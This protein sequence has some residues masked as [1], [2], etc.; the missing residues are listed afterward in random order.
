MQA[1]VPKVLVVSH[2]YGAHGG[3]IERVVDRLLQEMSAWG[4]CK[5]I[6]AASDVDPRPE[7][8]S[9]EP[10]PMK[11]LNLLEKVIGIPWPVWGPASLKRLKEQ[12]K[13]ADI[14]WLHDTLYAGNILAYYWAKHAG[15][16][17]VITQHI[18]PIPYRNPVLRKIMSWADKTFTRRMLKGASQT[19][20]ISDRIAE[21]YFRTVKFDHAVKIIPNGVDARTY[22]LPLLEK[23][24]Y[25][26][27]QFAL[28]ADQP[29]LLFVGR[30]VEKKGLSAI[31]HM[32]EMLPD[33]RFWLA[34]RGPINPTKWMRPNVHVFNDRTGESL[35]ELYQAADLLILPSYGEGFPLVIQEAMACGLPVMCSPQTAAGSFEAKPL[36]CLESVW[37]ND[38]KLTAV[39]WIQKLK[40]L[41]LPLRQP[42]NALTE[43]AQARWD[44]PTI[45][46][47]YGEV[48][49]DVIK[50]KNA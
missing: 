2:Y 4:D 39:T 40:S 20:F 27:Q 36:L 42:Q 14:V 18:G 12:V 21:E 26:R 11:T 5:F 8:P 7:K 48:F 46:N 28:K 23:R 19:L 35:T 15:K 43:F 24:H 32:A 45:A 10:L 17:V 13:K 30:F 9:V 49:S 16:P 50:R 38:P 41:A 44:W 31:R 37:P 33:W 29:V 25:L 22:H 3:G 47:A 1:T 6:W 34:G